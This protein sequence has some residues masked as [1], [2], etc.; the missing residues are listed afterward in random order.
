M[1]AQTVITVMTEREWRTAACAQRDRAERITGPARDRRARGISHPIE[2][3]LTQYYSAPIR[4]LEQWHPGVDVVLEI[5]DRE[6]A[7]Q[8]FPETL[9]HWEKGRLWADPCL[10]RDAIRARLVWV[11]ELLIATQNRVANFGCHGLH[12]W[13][14]VYQGVEIRHEA[15]APLR[16]P[17]EEIDALVTSRVVSC[18]HFDAFRFFAASAR[19]LN[20][21]QPTMDTR[22][23]HEQPG[24]LHANMDLYKWA[25]KAWPWVGSELLFE[26]Y[27]LAREI[28]DLDMRASPYDLTAWGRSTIAIETPEGRRCYEQMQRGFAERASVL[29]RRIIDVLTRVT[30]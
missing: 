1:A 15:V 25:S 6:E 8:R 30:P 2:D 24:C 28:R 4:R 23:D 21:L 7:Y 10:M 16:L 20:R 29:R 5:A 11:R 19:P 14:M 9:H 12:E 26:T 22:Q 27:R 17:Q 3:F 13:A 18:S